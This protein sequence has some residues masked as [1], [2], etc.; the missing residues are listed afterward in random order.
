MDNE[1][2]NE[3]DTAR[4]PRWSRRQIL[5][6]GLGGVAGIVVAGAA[7]VELVSHGVLPG[8]QALTQLEGGCSVTSPT[9]QY[10]ELGHSLSGSFHSQARRRAVGYTV[11]WPPGAEPGTPLPLI[12]MLHGEGANHTNALTGMRPNE[13][14]ALTINGKPLP[15][16]ALV[17][18][19]GGT[20]Y[21]NPHPDDNPMAMVISEL[22]PLC[23]SMHLGRSPQKI[24]TMGISM[25]GYGAILL[26]EKYPRT[27]PRRGRH[28]SRHLDQLRRGA[29]RESRRLCV[30][31]GLHRQRRSQSHRDSFR[32]RPSGWHPAT[33]THSTPAWLLWRNNC[34]RAPRSCSRRD[35]TP[36]P[37]STPRSHP[38]CSFSAS[39]WRHDA[40][41]EG[42]A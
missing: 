28:Q 13:A 12:V 27:D 1:P 11:A 15:P 24:G 10:A 29:C 17:T 38:R 40:A 34:Q 21:W 20:G 3:H 26:A 32:A 22:I 36:V 18:V 4:R 35:V 9:F 31:G 33:T 19:D 8:K 16:M 37:S 5:T 30:S 25:G 39:T 6:A 2:S 7:G 41:S 14:V 23:Q 42:S